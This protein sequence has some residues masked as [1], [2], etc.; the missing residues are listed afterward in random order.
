MGEAVESLYVHAVE[1]MVT[2]QSA[3]DKP[4]ALKYRFHRC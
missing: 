2:R 3:A 4:P 1:K